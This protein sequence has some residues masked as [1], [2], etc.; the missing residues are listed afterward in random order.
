MLTWYDSQ[1]PVQVYIIPVF[2]VKN[3]TLIVFAFFKVKVK[4]VNKQST[5]TCVRFYMTESSFLTV[6][7]ARQIGKKISG[8]KYYNAEC[9]E[10][11]QEYE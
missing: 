7:K 2:G 11:V 10:S 1:K 3:V 9:F 6:C 5:F 8:L 4:D